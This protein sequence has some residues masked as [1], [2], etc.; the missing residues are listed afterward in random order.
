[1]QLDLRRYQRLQS[2]H[3]FDVWCSLFQSMH[4]ALLVISKQLSS[5]VKDERIVLML[6]K[7]LW[8]Q[9]VHLLLEGIQQI[10]CQLYFE[11][12]DLYNLL[13]PLATM[14]RRMIKHKY[15]PTLQLARRTIELKH[16][17]CVVMPRSCHVQ[18]DK[19]N[20]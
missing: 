10:I 8:H 7:L 1:M 14:S 19:M 16:L 9:S 15:Q 5:S 20:C 6:T 17:V 2:I 12:L 11:S 13:P 4:I 18:H 3:W